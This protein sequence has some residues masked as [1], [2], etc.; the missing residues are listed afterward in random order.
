MCE[1]FEC[2]PA[3][4]GIEDQ[5]FALMRGIVENRSVREVLRIE[6]SGSEQEKT[7]LTEHPGMAASLLAIKEAQQLVYSNPAMMRAVE[8]VRRAEKEQ[9]R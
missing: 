7:Y 5:D 8:A 4:G 3:P 9:V 6:Q 2:L 1:A